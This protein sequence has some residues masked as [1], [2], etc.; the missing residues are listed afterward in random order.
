[1]DLVR[2]NGAKQNGS[3]STEFINMRQSSLQTDSPSPRTRN[4]E[5]NTHFRSIDETGPT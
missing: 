5:A 4:F 3:Q 1:M 2:G